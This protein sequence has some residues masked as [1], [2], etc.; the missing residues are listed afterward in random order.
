MVV[1]FENGGKIGMWL[2][3][4][5]VVWALLAAVGFWWFG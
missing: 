5:L 4:S 2:W 3:C 1:R